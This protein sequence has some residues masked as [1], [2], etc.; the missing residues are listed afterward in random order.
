M[1]ATAR[2][3]VEL[4]ADMRPTTKSRVCEY[5]CDGIDKE[6]RHLSWSEMLR[7]RSAERWSSDGLQ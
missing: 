7:Y 1:R 4:K 5:T 3:S 6:S 2:V